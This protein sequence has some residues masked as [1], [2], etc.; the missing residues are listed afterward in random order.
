LNNDLNNN[1]LDKN[2]SRT[3]PKLGIAF[4]GG[5]IRGMAHIGL[6]EELDKRGIRA[7]MVAGTSIGSLIGSLYACGY[8]GKFLASLI[9]NLNLKQIMAISPTTTGLTSG[10]NYAEFARIMTKG[11]NIEETEIPLRIVATDL[12]HGEMEVFDKGPIWR[13]VHA[14]SAVPGVF[15]PVEYRGRS[16]VD[17]CLVDNCPCHIL[18]EMG[19][20]VVIGVDLDKL[21]N[22]DEP[23]HKKQ[24]I[25]DILQRSVDVVGLKNNS[26]GEADVRLTPMTKYIP[27]MDLNKVE[28]ALECGR[29]EAKAK[30]DE[31]MTLL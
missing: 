17:G 19:A 5:G 26:A 10:R 4:G 27:S 21:K 3:R 14:S 2:L 20:D 30:I 12:Q 1:N 29:K 25:I 11:R 7:D 24:N 31:I 28:Y 9:E 23:T 18:R 8:K 15:S 6:I 22:Y 16:F 13:A